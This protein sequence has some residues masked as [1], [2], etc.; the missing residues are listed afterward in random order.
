MTRFLHTIVCL[1]ISA[2]VLAEPIQSPPVAVRIAIPERKTHVIGD[3]IE[4]N[5]TFQNNS[6]TNLAFMWEGCC[7]INGRV[8][9]KRKGPPVPPKDGL[10]PRHSGF[11]P[12]I[13]N[14][15]CMHCRL[16]KQKKAMDVAPAPM[17]PA[18][19][20][21]F[22]RPVRLPAGAAEKISS[23]LANWVLLEESGDY[24][25]TGNYLGVHPKQ[26]PQ[27][28]RNARLWTEIATSTPVELSLL[29]PT[30]YLAERPARSQVR[31]ASLHLEAV[32][33]IQPFKDLGLSL[34]VANLT[35][36]NLTLHWP[37]QAEFWLI[38]DKDVRVAESRYAITDYGDPINI[39]PGGRKHLALPVS[40][41][42][43]AGKPFGRYRAFVELKE[44]AEQIRTPSNPVALQWH[45]TESTV[46]GLLHDAG[47]APAVGH[48][49][50]PLKL[51]RQ[52]LPDLRA[53]LARVDLS[54]LGPSSLQLAAE[55]K[56]AAILSR[57]HPQPGQVSINIALATDGSAR[58]Q[59]PAISQA[60]G[61]SYSTV[62]D[63]LARVIELRRHLGWSVG[64]ALRIA[65]DT[66]LIALDRLMRAIAP[67]RSHLAGKPEA[68]AFNQTATAFSRITFADP[69]S[70]IA[71]NDRAL[72]SQP[73]KALPSV[74]RLIAP[75]TLTWREMLDRTAPLVDAG[76]DY[77]ILI[78]PQ[79]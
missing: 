50:P 6:E 64:L 57:L 65:P 16:E 55:L 13:Y 60:F 38:D 73:V 28:P 3:V 24:V 17:G 69:D 19:A 75:A 22:A 1:L 44:T 56:E 71:P 36:S 68:K 27:M 70:A 43:F 8:D 26:Q 30:D 47:A 41:E 31:G 4:L 7:R 74:S 59:D 10:R 77:E 14:P 72:P 63:R 21:M 49:N 33:E 53:T 37:G 11:G 29:S 9:M 58:F 61:S 66:Q 42:I 2:S 34:S 32:A 23:R 46:H 76:K 78:S 12:G 52:H 25:L 79:P 67:L 48:R 15:F 39:P 54:G 20:H 62:H 45:L 18:T 35:T 5:W 51:L 40:S